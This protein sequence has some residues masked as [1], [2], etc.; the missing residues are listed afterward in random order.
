MQFLSKASNIVQ[1]I[2]CLYDVDSFTQLWHLIPV[3]TKCKVKIY[4]KI[5]RNNNRMPQPAWRD[6]D[7]VM[8]DLDSPMVQ[9]LDSVVNSRA[10]A[11]LAGIRFPRPSITF[12]HGMGR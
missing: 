9:A 5:F 4:S 2:F 12:W 6:V 10:A 7:D 11:Y 1:N 8:E 3:A